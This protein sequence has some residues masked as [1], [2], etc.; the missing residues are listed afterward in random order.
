MRARILA[1][2]ISFLPLSYLGCSNDGSVESGGGDG[3]PVSEEQLQIFYDTEEPLARAALQDGVQ[4]LLDASQG[5]ELD[6]ISVLPTGLNSYSLNVDIDLDGDGD[7]EG[8]EDARL[9][10]LVALQGDP[11]NGIHDGDLPATVQIQEAETPQGSYSA[12]MNVETLGGGE[13]VTIFLVTG[14]STVVDGARTE[15]H[16]FGYTLDYTFPGIPIY[17]WEWIEVTGNG[18]ATYNVCYR[19][20][21]FGIQYMRVAGE[22]NGAPFELESGGIPMEGSY[23]CD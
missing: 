11:T 19:T 22:V 18:T 6:G 10:M 4:R 8:S 17:G 1:L 13:T 9:P 16:E 5:G 7:L 15:L 3:T 2:S 14:T 21:E 12:D 23:P 20:N